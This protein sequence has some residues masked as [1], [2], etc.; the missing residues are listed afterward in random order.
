MTTIAVDPG[1]TG[2]VAVFHGGSIEVHDMPTLPAR[3]GR[4]ELNHHALLD[5]LRAVEPGTVWLERVS[6]M[7]GQGVT[8]MFR[9]GQGYGAI[10]MAVAASGHVLRYVTPQQ[11]KKHFGLIG[12]AKDASRAVACQRLPGAAHL[13]ARKKDGGRADAAL[14]G[15]YGIEKGAAA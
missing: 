3:S 6:A 4:A 8:S 5:I 11:W 12:A 15:L 9:F 7:P 13:F 1:F 14:I 10:E 2:A